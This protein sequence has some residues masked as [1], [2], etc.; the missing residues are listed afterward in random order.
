[1]W[2]RKKIQEM[3]YGKVSVPGKIFEFVLEY[4]NSVKQNYEMV[5]FLGIEVLSFSPQL[6]V[7]IS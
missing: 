2:F 3:L 6:F 5:F 1:M 7:C 4:I